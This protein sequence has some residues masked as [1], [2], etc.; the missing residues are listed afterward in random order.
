[1]QIDPIAIAGG[2]VGSYF[3]PIQC[4]FALGAAGLGFTR[5]PLWALALLGLYV[6]MKVGAIGA[7]V[8]YAVVVDVAFV[9]LNYAAGWVVGRLL[10]SGPA[11]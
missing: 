9:S 4:L 8:P 1:V 11:T 5:R 3:D 10:R 2:V 7:V 6:A